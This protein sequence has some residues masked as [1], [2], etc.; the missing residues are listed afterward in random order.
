MSISA[1][2][3]VMTAPGA[4]FEMENLLIRGL[5]TRLWKNAPPTLR[6]VVELGRAHGEAIFLIHEDERISFEAFFRAV[7][8]RA[9]DLRANGVEKG[10]RVTLTMRNLPEWPV[11][12]Y[13]AAALRAIV[14]P[15]NAWGTGPELEYGLLDSGS[16]VL[17]VGSE[18]LAR[19]GEHLPRCPDLE[20]VYVAGQEEAVADPRI[21]RLESVIGSPEAL[22]DLPVTPLRD[23]EIAPEDDATIFYTSGTTGKPKGAIAS[24][25]NVSSNT[26]AAACVGARAFLRR[27]ETPPAPRASAPRRAILLSAPFFHAT[28]CMAILNP[29]LMAGAKLAMMRR[30]DPG[31]AF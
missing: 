17:F 26:M 19:L 2:H 31:R 24:Q 20:H 12:F 22:A 28:C 15:L 6:A 4:L 3:A 8:I 5:P 14:T 21:V 13:A 29:G 1:A 30:W 25:R 9:R 10:D 16:K 7:G 18:R 27:G 11:P 23:A